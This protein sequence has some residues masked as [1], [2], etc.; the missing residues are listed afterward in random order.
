MTGQTTQ[1]FD[2]NSDSNSIGSRAITLVENQSFFPSPPITPIAIVE[3]TDIRLPAKGSRSRSV[4]LLPPF[5]NNSS[6]FSKVFHRQNP[7][8][9]K[10][11]NNRYKKSPSD[12][13]FISKNHHRIN[14]LLGLII[15]EIHPFNDRSDLS[16]SS[17]QRPIA[18]HLR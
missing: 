14:L 5:H 10:I 16:R 8:L 12:R 17:H 4:D 13:R 15:I 6:K 1:N 18:R 7:L 9:H 2:R 11:G 3:N